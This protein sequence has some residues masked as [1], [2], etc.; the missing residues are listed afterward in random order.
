MTLKAYAK[1]KAKLKDKTLDV[2]FQGHI[3]A[4]VGVIN[5]YMDSELLYTW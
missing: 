1:L 3:T 5:L 4:M 2:V